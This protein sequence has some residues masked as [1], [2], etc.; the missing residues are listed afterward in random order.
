MARLLHYAA[1][2][3]PSSSQA[4]RAMLRMV[5]GM[6]GITQVDLYAE[7]PR[8]DIDIA[9]EQ[10]RLLAHDVVVL[11]F[12]LFWYSCPALVKEWLDLVW[13]HGFAYG[14]QGDKLK[15]KTLLLAITTGGPQ[16][17]YSPQGYQHFELRTFLTPF[18]QTARLAQMRFLAPYVFHGA[19]KRDPAAH[20]LGFGTLL[21]ALRDE[22]LDL[23][24]AETTDILTHDTLPLIGIN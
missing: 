23:R 21:G 13:E 18:E 8:Y 4:N 20:A 22:R 14:Q 5:Q 24:A 17:A 11:Q 12:P 15:G 7:Y 9:E 3:A 16:E 6:E 1:H 2:P 10:A 19:L